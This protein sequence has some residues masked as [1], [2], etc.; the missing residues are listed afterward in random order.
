M[1]KSDFVQQSAGASTAVIPFSR[2]G[3]SASVTASR[4]WTASVT[5]PMFPKDTI[6]GVHDAYCIEPLLKQAV[7][8]AQVSGKPL[9]LLMVDIDQFRQ[10]NTRF[11][12]TA[13]D[14]VL[15]H[16]AQLLQQRT[17]RKDSW[18]AR[19]GA[20]WFVVCLPGVNKASARRVANS[21]RVAIMG[22][23]WLLGGAVAHV[24]CCFGVESLLPKNSTDTA[25]ELLKRTE[26]SLQQAKSLG[27]NMIV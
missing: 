8:F 13:G 22:E 21:L 5:D 18:V 25:K 10:I 17:R 20:D 2:L 27:Q 14:L 26:V 7:L 15:Q 3:G 1:S 23:K 16:I 12:V 4:A 19:L 6:T 9:S 11:G 24:T